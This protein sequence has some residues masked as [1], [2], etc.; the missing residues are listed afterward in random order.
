NVIHSFDWFNQISNCISGPRALD[1]QNQCRT[2]LTSSSIDCRGRSPGRYPIARDEFENVSM[3]TFIPS[4]QWFNQIS[5]CISG[6]RALVFQ[7]QCLA[8]LTSSSIDGRGPSPGQYPI[9]RDEFE[10][11][12]MLNFIPSFHWFDQTSNCISGSRALDCQ[13][14]CRAFLT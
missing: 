3:C 1:F 12:S 14:Q 2:L 8:L 10:N 7:S 11:V 6:S 5:N 9:R 4:F 13:S